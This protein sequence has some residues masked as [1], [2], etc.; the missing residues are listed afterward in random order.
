MNL[1][2]QQG[3]DEVLADDISLIYFTSGTS[4]L[5]KMVAHKQTYGLGHIPTAKY[6]HKVE[7]D[8]I[9]HTA[10]DTGWGKSSLGKLL[11]TMDCR[12]CSF[13]I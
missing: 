12:I 11:R 1:K 8:G 5:P 7:E 4:G 10:A 6:W 9:H 2:D 13:H 3:D